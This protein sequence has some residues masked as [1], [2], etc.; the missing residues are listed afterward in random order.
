MVYCPLEQQKT[1]SS[2]TAC[3]LLYSQSAGT[4]LQ[5]WTMLRLSMQAHTAKIPQWGTMTSSLYNCHP[6]ASVSILY[7][8]LPHQ[9]PASHSIS[10]IGDLTQHPQW[11]DV[12]GP[13][14]HSAGLFGMRLLTSI[15]SRQRCTNSNTSSR[16]P[17]S[18]ICRNCRLNK[19]MPATSGKLKVFG[20]NS[21]AG[22]G[23]ICVD[24]SF[25]PAGDKR[26]GDQKLFSF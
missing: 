13:Q 20:E 22:G 24:P 2:F 7:V 17:A 25:W 15:S 8:S 23:F 5:H 12:S 19:G 10:P 4:W 11:C 21:V 18:F 26:G 6:G 14:L 1:P 9:Q 3:L 16:K